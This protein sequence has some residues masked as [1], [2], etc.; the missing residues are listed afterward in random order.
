MTLVVGV[1]ATMK[2]WVAVVAEDGAFVEARAFLTIA[3]LA[4]QLTD[5]D[6]IGVDIPIGLP[7]SGRRA[8]DVAAREF[9]GPRRS[10]VFFTHPLAVIEAP[11]YADAREIAKQRFGTGI[12]AQAYALR[13]KI[14]EVD[15]IVESDDRIIEVHPEVSF[16]ELAGTHLLHS[17]RTWN[18]QMERRRLLADGEIT[19]PGHLVEAGDIPVDDV[20]DAAVCAWTAARFAAGTARSMPDP[21]EISDAGRPMAIWL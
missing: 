9:V 21:P 19:L 18:G 6:V 20:L 4:S 3:E 12:S 10:S 1:D 13:N 8:A 5:V 2:G 15:A 11:T 7:D 17:K 14:L 16:R